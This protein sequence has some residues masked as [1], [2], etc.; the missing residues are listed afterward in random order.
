MSMLYAVYDSYAQWPWDRY[1]LLHLKSA[2]LS[3]Y[4]LSST[5]ITGI[6]HHLQQSLNSHIADEEPN[7]RN[8][9]LG[10]VAT[11]CAERF[12]GTRHLRCVFHQEARSTDRHQVSI[13]TTTSAR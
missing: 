2:G 1:T 4:R 11:I 7:L 9:S 13:E 10:G 5:S 12:L 8:G 6:N 3:N